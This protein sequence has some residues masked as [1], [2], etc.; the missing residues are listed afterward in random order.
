MVLHGDPAEELTRP[1]T[2]ENMS[3]PIKDK[4]RFTAVI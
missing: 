2:V 4:F 1:V 3:L